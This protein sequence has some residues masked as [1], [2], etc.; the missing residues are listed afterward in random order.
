MIGDGI[1][2]DVIDEACVFL[3]GACSC[4]VKEQNPGVDLAMAVDWDRL[5]TSHQNV[6]REL[7]PLSGFIGF[8]EET[9][10]EGKTESER[11]NLAS[12]D[13]DVVEGET[14]D[15]GLSASFVSSI[16]VCGLLGLSVFVAGLVL[17]R[18]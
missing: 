9:Q 14:E 11:I 2:A 12:A 7:P 15:Q 1:A 10:S 13:A 4:E 6:D 18:P 17:L 3:T 16:V 5:V 8:A